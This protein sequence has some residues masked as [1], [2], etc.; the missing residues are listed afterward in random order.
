MKKKMTTAPRRSIR[1]ISTPRNSSDNKSYL[2]LSCNINSNI[3]S[4]KQSTESI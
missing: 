2:D 1:F 3:N 4:H